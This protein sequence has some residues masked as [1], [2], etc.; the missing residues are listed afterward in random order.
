MRNLTADAS[1]GRGARKRIPNAVPALLPSTLR[2][3]PTKEYAGTV[4]RGGSGGA[5]RTTKSWTTSLMFHGDVRRPSRVISMGNAKTCAVYRPPTASDVVRVAEVVPPGT[6]ISA[7]SQQD[8]ALPGAIDTRY[9]EEGVVAVQV[10]TA[11]L[12]VAR[13]ATIF[14]YAA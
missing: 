4:L 12:A 5:D 10:M 3:P 7:V 1:T 14:G 13:I 8:E 11:P 9:D 6:V 2:V